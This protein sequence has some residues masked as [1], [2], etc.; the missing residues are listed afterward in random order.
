MIESI[1]KGFDVWTDAQGVKSK[2]RVKSLDNISLE[3]IARLRELII[4]SAIR[5]KLVTQNESNQTAE[6]FLIDCLDEIARIKKLNNISKDDLISFD[7]KN[8][9][10]PLPIKWAWVT[11]GNIALVERG[12]SPRPIAHYLTNASDGLNWIKIGDTVKGSKYITATEEKIRKEGL[13]KTRL[14]YPGDFLLTNSMS[15]GRPYI[16]KIEGCI[17][18]GWLRIHFPCGLNTDFLYYLL[19][20]RYVYSFFKNAAA[21]AVVQNLNSEKVRELPIPIPPVEEQLRIV[22]KIEELIALCDRLEENQYKNL[23]THHNLVKCL[24]ETLTQA[25]DAD[26]LQT[27]WQKL[28]EHFDSLLCTEDSIEQLRETIIQLALRGKLTKQDPNDENAI[29]LKNKIF[30]DFERLAKEGTA[31]KPVTV[32]EINEEEMPYS[33]PINWAWVRLQEIIQISSGDGLTAS[34]M[35]SN[36]EIPVYGGNGVNGYHDKYNVTKPTLVIGRVGFYCGSIH[37]TPANA[38]VTDNA[39]ITTFSEDNISI[40]FLY[41][42]LKGTNLKENDNATAQPVISGRKIY[43]IVV[44]L[45]PFNEQKRIVE[46][47]NSLFSICETLKMKIE[48][49][50]EVKVTLS[51]TII[52][53]AI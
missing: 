40:D 41:W 15:F 42:L 35:N 16:S 23:S 21:G 38:W 32:A 51:K 52:A 45:P 5:G 19:S 36:G 47:I 12:G 46:I 10:F 9:P 37:I 48:K 26:E 11:L 13:E 2:G 3:G 44:G 1:I 6:Q 50:Q 17:H 8:E 53:S 30:H 22:E 33:L 49:S 43:P 27:A 25:N 24:L 39:F 29:E 31:K 18:D 14:V 7:S 34:N 28:A 20:S 4:D